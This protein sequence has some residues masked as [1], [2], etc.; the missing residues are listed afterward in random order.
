MER[1]LELVGVGLAEEHLLVELLEA[2]PLK[3][4]LCL[5]GCPPACQLAYMKTT[6]F[7]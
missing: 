4:Y 1:D 2:Q 7:L 6:F 5:S 3:R